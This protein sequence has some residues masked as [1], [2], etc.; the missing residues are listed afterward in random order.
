[1]TTP[2]VSY[3][4]NNWAVIDV[5]FHIR[6]NTLPKPRISYNIIE[7]IFDLAPHDFAEKLRE[8]H[9]SAPELSVWTFLAYNDF[10]GV[11]K[12]YSHV[13]QAL[14]LMQRIAESYVRWQIWEERVLYPRLGDGLCNGG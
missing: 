14:A 2:S 13:Y 9:Q 10:S 4:S 3:S 8:A 1:M 12:Q 5:D 7:S 6:G 11:I